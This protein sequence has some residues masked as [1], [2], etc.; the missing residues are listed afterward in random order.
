MIHMEL[1]TRAFEAAVRKLTAE[2]QAE[3][4]E[5]VADAMAFEIQRRAEKN[6]TEWNERDQVYDRHR[7][8]YRGALIDTGL[9]RGSFH[10]IAS[11]RGERIV[12]NASAYARHHEFGTKSNKTNKQ[13]IPARPFLRPA[14]TENQQGIVNTATTVLNAFIRERSR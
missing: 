1:D 6:I 5:A 7:K 3:G 10:V 2:L 9:M 14:I 4:T 12:F 8:T 13:I 11:G